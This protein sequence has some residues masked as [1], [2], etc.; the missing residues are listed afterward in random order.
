MTRVLL[1]LAP[2]LERQGAGFLKKPRRQTDLADV[3]NQPAQMNEPLLLFGEAQPLGDVTRV[4]RDSRRVAGR[5]S[6]SGV[7]S[8][9]R[10][11]SR[12]RGSRAR[13]DD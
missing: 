10:A 2:L 7:E 12:K 9:D 6:V 1:H 3:V 4:D 11:R 13:V 8:G 5:V